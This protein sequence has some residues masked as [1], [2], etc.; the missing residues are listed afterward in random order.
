LEWLRRFNQTSQT[1]WIL[2]QVPLGNSNMLD[3]P[4]DCATPTGKC[5]P[6]AG[7]KDNRVEYM[8]N[9]D[10][11]ASK[12]IRDAHLGKLADAGVISIWFGA[13]AGGSTTPSNDTW[14]DGQPFLKSRFKQ[15]LADTNGG[16]FAIARGTGASGGS[17]GGTG[18][19]G[20][21]GGNDLGMNADLAM[22]G[23]SG[24]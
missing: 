15:L 8:L 18:G 9:Y 5:T 2:H 6:R 23:G 17:T 3:V 21:G 7:Y 11:P 1:R 16:G 13:G 24:G 22:G 10:S 14:T 4:S 20:G 12:A 19:G